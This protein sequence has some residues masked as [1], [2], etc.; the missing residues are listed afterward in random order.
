MNDEFNNGR[1]DA[2]KDAA[3]A[4]M[5][6]GLEGKVSAKSAQECAAIIVKMLRDERVAIG[7]DRIAV[8]EK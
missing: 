7:L 8:V 3:I 4:V 1:L 6:A 2:L 5:Q